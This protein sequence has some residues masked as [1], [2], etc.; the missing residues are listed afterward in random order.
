MEEGKQGIAKRKLTPAKRERYLQIKARMMELYEEDGKLR[1][2]LA[3]MGL[4]FER[5]WWH[6][7]LGKP[8][9]FED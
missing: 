1:A 5:K 6:G 4:K 7:P 9:N 2:E 3:A 8:A